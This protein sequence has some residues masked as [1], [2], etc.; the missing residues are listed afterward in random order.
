MS[1]LQGVQTVSVDG[2]SVR[3]CLEGPASAPVLMFGNGLAT[4]MAMWDAQ[5]SYFSQRFRMLRYDTRGHGGT[6]ASSPPYSIEQLTDDVVGLLDRLDI[7]R[8]HYIGL[9]LGGMIGQSMGVR[10]S[11]RIA[12][13]V[14]CDTAMRMSREMWDERIAAIEADGLEPQVESSEPENESLSLSD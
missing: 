6:E 7:A 12:S 2:V 5:A 10:H 4:N 11:D 3:C 1:A 8:V 9:S 13:L 14:L